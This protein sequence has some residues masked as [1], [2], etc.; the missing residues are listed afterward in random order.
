[1][2][3]RKTLLGVPL[4]SDVDYF[5]RDAAQFGAFDSAMQE[6]GWLISSKDHVTTYGTRVDGDTIIV[7]AV[8]IAF[9]PSLE[10]VLDSFDFTITQFGYDGKDMVCGQFSLW[11][12]ARRRL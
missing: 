6:K 7:Q 9:Y 10:A 3:I 8:R 2:A 5:F 12:L 11:D 1:G 4:D